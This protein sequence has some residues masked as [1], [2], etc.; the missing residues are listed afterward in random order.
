MH[1][2]IAA[3][4]GVAVG[5]A[6]VLKNPARRPAE[7]APPGRAE[8]E[9]ASFAAALAAAS[10]ELARLAADLTARV[11]EKEG[12][13]FAAH[14]AILDDDELRR[15]VM[16]HIAAGKTAAWSVQTVFAA[17]RQQ[18]AALD[19]PYLRERAGDLDDLAGRLIAHLAGGG[20]SVRQESGPVIVVAHT[21]TPSETA[22]LDPAATLALVTA[23]G[24]P[25]SHTAILARA[26]GIPAVV[27]VAGIA[28]L[29]RDGDLLIVDGR[30]GLVA[31]NP[32]Q[33]T[34]HSYAARAAVRT[35]PVGDAGPAVTR[36][37][38]RLA[39]W[40]NIGRPADAARALACGAEG[41]GLFRSEFLFMDRAGLPDE[42]EQYA[43]YRQAAE[44][45]AGRPVVIRTLDAGGD[46]PLPGLVHP[47]EANPF[48][49]LRAIRLS[50]A[51]PGLFRVQLRAVL[52]AAAH[53]DVRLMYPM[54]AGTDEIQRANAL[55]ACCKAELAAA[56]IPHD[57]ALPVGIMVEI[58]AA[59]AAAEIFAR[60]SDFFSIGTNDLIQYSL[61]VDRLDQ[62]LGHLYRPLD[63]GVLRL[64][65][66][67]AAA[68]RAAGK[69]AGVCGEMAADPAGAL[70]LLGLGLDELSV[71]PASLPAVRRLVRA[72]A[73]ADARRLAG[74]ALALDSAAAVREL[75]ETYLRK[76]NI[77]I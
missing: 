57:P 60:H 16:D 6:A 32:D 58:P 29:V 62:T 61:A 70:L 35:A 54:I 25:T 36:D 20:P 38:H 67:A 13:I 23:T 7:N 45:M 71:S 10:D 65:A 27:G 9:A 30:Q 34:L 24:G 69:H 33:P 39:L 51:H 2:G 40:A 12:A 48:L 22:R 74:E 26:L 3:S 42:E 56:G 49:G 75:V 63:P 72:V 17:Y 77:D 41:I 64:I 59:A 31:V 73:F 11:G 5:R 15:G 37:G 18:F 53:G 43:A 21:L 19:D 55:L 52:R 50:L 8:A 46:K 44:T 4:E 66:M 14:I 28:G 76:I 47:G 1:S 68:A